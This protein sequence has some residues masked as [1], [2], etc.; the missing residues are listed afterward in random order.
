MKNSS[1]LGFTLLEILIFLLLLGV[2]ASLAFPNW[3]RLYQFW[4][5]KTAM[6]TIDHALKW[7]RLTALRDKHMTYFCL[8]RSGHCVSHDAKGFVI[9]YY[10]TEGDPVVIKQHQFRRHIRWRWH[11]LAAHHYIGFNAW[12]GSTANGHLSLQNNSSGLRDIV[13]SQTGRVRLLGS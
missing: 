9:F 8:T 3:G 6:H 13:V 11:G 7:A 1:A 12:G 5:Q 2:L 10:T 4:Q